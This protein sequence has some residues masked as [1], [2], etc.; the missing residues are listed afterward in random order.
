MKKR[1]RRTLGGRGEEEKKGEH[2]KKEIKI[3]GDRGEEK[4]LG[5]EKEAEKEEQNRNRQKKGR[6]KNM[7]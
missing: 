7:R 2:R 4:V 3:G 6:R 1:I 5:D